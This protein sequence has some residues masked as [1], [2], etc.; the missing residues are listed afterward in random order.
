[1]PGM[2]AMFIFDSSLKMERI[3]ASRFKAGQKV[4]L[5]PLTSEEVFVGKVAGKI[6]SFGCYVE[7]LPSAD[8]VNFSAGSL[9]N[10]F[11][12][13]V[14]QF[15]ELMQ[16]G[17]KDLKKV[18]AIDKVTSL[19][20][21]SLIS[22]KCPF[23]T[24]SF[25]KLAQLDAV[26]KSLKQKKA[27]SL[28]FGSTNKK[29]YICMRQYSLE[30]NLKFIY[31]PGRPTGNVR[32]FIKEFQGCYYLKHLFHLFYVAWKVFLRSL[33][34]KISLPAL[35]L[36]KFSREQLMVVT[37]Y[38]NFDKIAAKGGFFKNKFYPGLQE[39]LQLSKQDL[40]W[41]AM[42]VQNNMMTFRDSLRFANRF[43]D[44]G[45]KIFFLEEFSSFLL[46]VKAILMV[47]WSGFKF[48][49]IQKYI[50]A[51]HNI[52]GYNFYPLFKD[53]WYSSFSGS[54]AYMGVY[55]YQIFK[56][57][58]KY[59]YPQKC[60]Y[61]CEMHAWEKALIQARN[62]SGVKTKL[63]AYQAGTISSMLLNYF[64]HP[65]EFSGNSSYS[66]P[67]PDS[68]ACNGRVPYDYMRGSGWPQ[69]NLC[70][71]EAFRYNHLNKL[72]LRG[73]DR[74]KQIAMLLLSI[75]PQESSAILNLAKQA[76]INIRDIEVWV[77]PHPFLR[78]DRVPVL[79]DII[80][81]GSLFKV[82][83]GPIEDLLPQASV[84]IA[85]ETGTSIE[86]L[87][88]RCRVIIVN[89][90]EWINMSPLSNIKSSLVSAASSSEHLRRAILDAIGKDEY[91][92]E[93]FN[94]AD[95]ILNDFFYFNP[96]SDVPERFLRFIGINKEEV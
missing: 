85:G 59:F 2:N 82:Q 96:N 34:I 29:L 33:I 12:E 54:S 56:R 73:Q 21:F 71:V 46:Q 4:F 53:D 6:S 10:K 90:P 94:E 62:A 86:A 17:G 23:K 8:L 40:N 64:N 87:A 65:K 92:K 84:V 16:V 77:K 61:S 31:M 48:G 25:N 74:K 72:L 63:Y 81:N 41:V 58:L 95:K 91:S 30:N 70:I 66:M 9:K 75:S 26:I 11:I 60:L 44:K 50:Q 39:G 67:R 5:F 89:T 1:M 78:V 83:N 88:S 19:W 24:D 55:Y 20:W 42:Y 79:M 52:D 47:F 69:D 76:F 35:G 38:P 7:V 14:A 18:F 36:R 80:N 43:I 49:F 32:Q 51:R 93:D 22:E 13:F 3:L 15:S 45:H 57:I 27:D 28:Y 68:I 37:P